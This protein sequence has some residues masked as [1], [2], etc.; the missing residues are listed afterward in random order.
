MIE[1]D[2]AARCRR[3]LAEK[4]LKIRSQASCSDFGDEDY[5]AIPPE[6]TCTQKAVDKSGRVLC[7]EQPY[8]EAAAEYIR[9]L[10]KADAS[11][12]FILDGEG[13]SKRS[14][15]RALGLEYFDFLVIRIR[16]IPVH[17]Y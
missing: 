10:I 15:L 9:V 14:I 6:T 12:Q 17:V 16:S 13:P 3:S 5:M 1:L 7:A 4:D 11:D 2:R 8:T